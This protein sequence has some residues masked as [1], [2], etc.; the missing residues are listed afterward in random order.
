[1]G[2]TTVACG[3]WDRHCQNIALRP[4]HCKQARSQ[5]ATCMH[6]AMMAWHEAAAPRR[7]VC[8][9]RFAGGQPSHEQEHSA[10]L[11][12]R[13]PGLRLARGPET[14]AGPDDVSLSEVQTRRSRCD[15]RAD[16]VRTRG[17]LGLG[18]SARAAATIV[19]P[20]AVA[21]DHADSQ[22]WPCQNIAVASRQHKQWLST[23]TAPRLIAQPW[24]LGSIYCATRKD[25]KLQRGASSVQGGLRPSHKKREIQQC[26]SSRK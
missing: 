12:R 11:R 3:A 20:G 21:P 4:R 13:R 25:R 7:Q 10:Q 9:V 2:C 17:S 5:D 1:V 26:A 8:L 16:I 24:G 6:V 15:C 22:S 19:G 18:R 14:A 23:R